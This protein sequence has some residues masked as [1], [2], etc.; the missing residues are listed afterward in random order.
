KHNINAVRTS[1]YANHPIWFDLC[2]RFGIYLIGECNLESHQLRKHVPDS[3]PRWKD[4][5][6]D[7]MVRMVERDKNHPSIVMWSLGNEA[8]FGSNFKHMYNA[9]KKID[10]TRPIHYE[11]DYAMEIADVQSSMYSPVEFMEKLARHEYIAG[12]NLKPERYKDKPIMLCEYSHAMGN[13]CGSFFDYI[14]LFEKYEQIIGGFIWDWVDQGLRQ[15]DDDGQEFWAY[16]GD[17]GDD[18]NDK[19]FCINGL[20]GPDRI[21]HPHL[22]E[23]KK[24]YQSIKTEAID[25]IEGTFRITNQYQFTNLDFVD[26]IWTITEDGAV[27]QEGKIQALN[28]PPG[29]SRNFN[30]EI[31]KELFNDNL[32]LKPGAEYFINFSFRLNKDLAW[33]KTGHEVAWDQF[34]LPIKSPKPVVIEPKGM[35]DLKL[36]MYP[37]GDKIMIAGSGVSVS[38]NRKT[39]ILESYKVD[40]HEFIKKPPEPN[41]WRA[42]TEN[43]KAGRMN[44]W[45]GYFSPEYQAE[46]AEFLGIKAKQIGP[47]IVEIVSKTKRITGDELE[48][49]GTYTT[50]YT[51]FGNGDI[52]IKNHFVTTAIAPRFGM[53]MEIPGIYKNITWFGRGWHET[54]WDRKRSG[55]IGLFKAKIHK[56]V[57]Q[58]VVPQENGNRTDVRWWAMQDDD[59]R[60]LIFIGDQLLSCSAWPYTQKTLDEALHVNELLPFS[61]NI[62]VNIDLKQM[63]IGGGGCG[64]LPPEKFMIGPGEYEYSF[65][66][67]PYKPSMGSLTEI[68]R[69]KI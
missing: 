50:T 67:R 27:I 20:V 13:S 58:Y 48:A 14:E 51:I 41:F 42:L 2:D 36:I 6:V 60:G 57:H 40:G 43:D 32:R 26:L 37:D 56:I 9:A 5:C 8:G 25:L 28:I 22:I 17:F 12:W 29:E 19:S 33:A 52:R 49:L 21:P 4:A 35:P 55:I 1:H 61:E 63:G 24:G 18:P 47:K 44:F 68:A 23:V 31:N 34:S 30:I 16:G 39:G 7:R 66:I 53:Q 11:G 59:G 54:Y 45:F 10:P 3:D 38:F 46:N 64:A 65:V 15:V 69:K 62:T